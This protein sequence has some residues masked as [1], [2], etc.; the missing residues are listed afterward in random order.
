[1]QLLAEQLSGPVTL[2]GL[3]QVVHE[4][5][6]ALVAR[7]GHLDTRLF[8]QLVQNLETLKLTSTQLF[9]PGGEPLDIDRLLG[10]GPCARPGFTRLTVISTK[11]F[12][13]NT[14]IQFWVAQLLMAALRWASKNPR[15]SLQAALL[16]DEADLYLPAQSKPATKAPMEDLLKRGRSAGLGMLLATQSPGDLDYR[17]RDNIGTWFLGRIKESTA[18]QKLRPMLANRPD[19]LERLPEQSIGAFHLWRPASVLAFQAGL[20][21]LTTEQLRGAGAA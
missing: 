7:I 10:T 5:D 4:N 3:I 17:C 13:D 8:G 14:Q 16:F 1:M 15:D 2:D 9:A 21:V 19:V 12:R 11:F 6:P 18:L 20:S